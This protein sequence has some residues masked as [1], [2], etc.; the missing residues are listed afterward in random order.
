ME[1]IQQ[2]ISLRTRNKTFTEYDRKGNEKMEQK[3]L[4]VGKELAA[5]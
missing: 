4:K 5:K 1:S 2:L 3:I